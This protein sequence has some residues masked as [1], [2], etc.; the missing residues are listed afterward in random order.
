MSIEKMSGLE[1]MQAMRDGKLPM[2]SIAVTIPMKGV[3]V[4]Q[5]RIVFEAMADDRHLNPM[6][7][8]HGGFIATV[9]DAVTGCAVHTTLGPGVGYGTIEL[10]VK[11]LKAVPQN[12]PLIAEGKVIHTTRTLGIA[13]GT[14]KDSDGNFYAH[15]TATCMILR[16]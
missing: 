4:E 13:E 8:V 9:L 15:A 16:R 7:G 12:V 6:G 5:G 14:L 1:I 3:A 11:M 10:N 2:P